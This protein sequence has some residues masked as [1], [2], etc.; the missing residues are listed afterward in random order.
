LVEPDFHFEAHFCPTPKGL[1][2]LKECSSGVT[3]PCPDFV[4]GLTIGQY[5]GTE[6]FEDGDQFD[7]AVSN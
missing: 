4:F 3:Y 1:L 5:E 2:E 7:S 6:V